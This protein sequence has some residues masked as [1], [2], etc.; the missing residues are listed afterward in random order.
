MSGVIT[1]RVCYNRATQNYLQ[2]TV[3]KM[4]NIQILDQG[5]SLGRGQIPFNWD[6]LFTDYELIGSPMVHGIFGGNWNI[7]GFQ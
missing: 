2:K 3:S 5:N 6:N 4:D 7:L 1:E